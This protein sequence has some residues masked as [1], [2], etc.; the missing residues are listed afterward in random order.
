MAG[1]I[2]ARRHSFKLFGQCRLVYDRP[3]FVN[4][5]FAKF[6]EDI[7]R[8]MDLFSTGPK[9][10]EG[11]HWC[12]IK[13]EPAGY[14]VVF[15]NKHVDVEVQIGKSSYIPEQHI[16]VIPAGYQLPV[17]AYLFMDKA[18]QGIN[19]ACVKRVD[20]KEVYGFYVS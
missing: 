8:K 5:A 4:P 19:I 13:N 7:F 9:A 20:V 16:L 11:F 17:V 10:K 1:L 14:G 15:N 6:I 2:R 18:C 12:A 3:D